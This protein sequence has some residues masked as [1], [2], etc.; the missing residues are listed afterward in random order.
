MKKSLFFILTFALFVVAFFVY[1]GNKNNLQPLQ[2][3][4]HTR[5]METITTSATFSAIG[6][7]LIHDTVYNKAYV[8]EKKYNFM[9]MFAQVKDLLS[10][11]DL[12]IANEESMIGGTGL[13]LSSYPMF[14][15][16]FEIGDALKECGID[17]VTIANNHSLDKRETGILKATEH[18]DQIGM[19]YTG[20]FRSQEDHDIIRVIDKNGITFSFLAYTYGT[21]GMVVPQ[22]KDYLVNLINP[23]KMKKDIQEAKGK[24][25]VV[26]VSMHFGE[27]YHR[28]PSDEQKK[29]VQQLA[30]DGADI[31][32]GHHPHV[33]QP[34]SWITRGNGEKVFV[35]YSLGNFISGQ[36]WDYKDIGGM[37]RVTVEKT[38]VGDKKKIQLKDPAFVPTWVDGSYHVIPLSQVKEKNSYYEAIQKHMRSLLPD[39]KFSLSQ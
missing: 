19:P 10:S 15:S 28:E 7:V 1:I 21:N 39:L 4:Q 18:W 25:D 27:E 31:I 26:V 30:E 13:G 23:E 20:A 38:V 37:V 9:P 2:P 17:L 3:K 36:K 29:L 34:V 6:D 32:I 35:A 24:S 5:T 12:T 14:N 8:G 22:G 11:S 33:L 16:P